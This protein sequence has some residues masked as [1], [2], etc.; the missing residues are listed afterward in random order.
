MNAGVERVCPSTAISG[1]LPTTG[2]SERGMAALCESWPLRTGGNW[3][4]FAR[5]RVRVVLPF[6]HVHVESFYSAV[7]QALNLR[8]RGKA[9]LVLDRLGI[10]SASPEAKVR[11]VKAG[12]SVGAARTS[13]PYMFLVPG[14]LARYAEVAERVRRVLRSY[15]ANLEMTAFGSFHLDFS[16]TKLS[17]AEFETK[18]RLMQAEILGGTGLH[19]SVGA[20]VSRG[21][22]T[23]AA[24]EHRPCGLRIVAP[25][26]ETAFLAPFPVEKLRGVGSATLA[27]LRQRGIHTIGQLQR[28]P[29]PAL[30]AALGATAG[31]RLWKAARG[32]DD[33]VASES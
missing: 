22:A 31:N 11:G 28:I 24:R 3:L 18:L 8:L 15:S 20:G 14:D 23:L 13:C 10:A 2:A 16:A 17:H 27:T 7:E 30:A 19:T 26:T 21:V 33:S 29:R 1:P 4:D 25:G 12:M 32:R 9:V 5:R 6:V